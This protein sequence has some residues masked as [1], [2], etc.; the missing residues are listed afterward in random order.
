M[1]FD[2]FYGMNANQFAIYNPEGNRLLGSSFQAQLT[3]PLWNWGA[4]Q[5]KLRQAHLRVQQARIELTLAQRQLLA[6]LT[7]FY[8]EAQVARDQV[9]SL[10][11]SLDLATES[12]RLTTL[13]YQAG[14]VSVLEVV[15]AQTTLSQARDAYNDGLVRTAWHWPRC[16]LSP[17]RYN[18]MRTILRLACCAAL[19][20]TVSACGKKEADT[21]PVAP[22]QVSPAVRGS[23]RHIVTADAVL[24][25]RDQ[26]NITPKISAPIRR[27]LVNRGN[28]VKRGQLLAELENRDLAAAAQES[29][30]QYA[31]AESNYH[32]TTEAAVPEQVTKAETDV[33]AARE[34]LDAAQKLLESRQQLLKEGATARKTVDEAQ[35]AYAQAKSQFDTADQHLKALQSVGKQEQIKSAAAQVEA[36]KDTTSRRRRRSGTADSQP[37]RWSDYRPSALPRGNGERGHAAHHR[38]GRVGGRRAREHV[39]GPGQRHQRRRRRHHHP[40]GRQRSR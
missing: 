28:R 1:S 17:E 32:A 6:S 25:P 38:D 23:I 29:R 34:A 11:T 31:Q 12:L 18:F 5:S 40:V 22:V 15:D 13:R 36:A 39:A 19:G 33:A 20:V 24:F 8:R 37:N 4:T 21:K 9:D 7:T 14:E 3:L 16:R 35:V 27:F 2:Y 26:A 30:G 10:R